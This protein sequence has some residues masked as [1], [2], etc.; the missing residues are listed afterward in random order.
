MMFRSL[1]ILTLAL[2]A[3]PAEAARLTTVLDGAWRFQRADVSGAEAPGFND[4]AWSTV[5][6]PHTYNVPD[7]ETGGMP[8]RGAAWYRRT[9]DVKPGAGMRRFL[10]FD[11]ATL[12][13][14]VYVNGRHAG[15]H[16]GGFAR[17]R[18]DIT[19]LLQ[20]GRNLLAVRVDNTRL[21]HVAPLGGDFTVFGG[22]VRPVRLVETPDT[23]IELLDHGGPGVRVDIETLDTTSARLKVQVQLRN[24]GRQPAGR[25]LRLTL[26]DAQGRSVVQQARRVSLP[27]GGADT[28]TALVN[29]RQPHLWQGIKDPYL[30]RLSAEL[31][32][33]GQVADAV[34]LPVGLRQFGVDPQRGFLLNGK[35]YPLYG[36][37]YFHAGR[38]GRGVAVGPAEIDEDLRILTEMGL[39]ALRLVHYQHPPYTYERAGPGAVDRDPAERRDGG[40]HRFPRQHLHAAARAGAAEPPP[41]VGGRLGRG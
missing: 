41:S 34:Q 1:L 25:E 37:N 18:F 14:D 24:D 19:P 5:A 22:L 3:L 21:P 36:V 35:P 40:D 33:A 6:L 31:V 38:P 32:E 12:A 27:A 9:L 8:Y 7:G 26:R 15:R 28:V 30:Y 39:T 20:P 4:A 13:A 10:E 29:V 2:S 23:H 16:E 11:G 17:F